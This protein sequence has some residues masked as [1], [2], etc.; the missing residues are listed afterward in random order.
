VVYLLTQKLDTITFTDYMESI[1]NPRE[2]PNL[3][4]FL[5]FLETKFKALESSRRN[6]DTPAPKFKSINK[7][8]S[9]NQSSFNQIQK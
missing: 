6:Q 3:K 9:K 7:N 1:K 8:Q 2:L 5:Q 4:E